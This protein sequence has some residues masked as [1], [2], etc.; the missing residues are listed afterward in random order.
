MLINMDIPWNPAVLEQRIARIYR[1]GQK[2]NVSIINMV[3]AG[4]IEQ[5]MLGVLGFKKGVSEG[6]LDGGDDT[7]FM[8]EGKFKM[9]MQSVETIMDKPVET[10]MVQDRSDVEA[11]LPEISPINEDNTVKAAAESLEILPGD[12]DIAR[13]EPVQKPVEDVNGPA[14]PAALVQMGVSF[15]SQLSQTLANPEATKK[16]VSSIVQKDETDGKT[17][18]KI[19]VENQQMVENAI[20]LF[21]GLM[22]AFN[23]KK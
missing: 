12:D 5:R 19:P 22:G 15:F 10:T 8:E 16:L 18:L 9:F 23:Q 6:I 13:Q 11:E 2:R 14:E 20:T 4:T 3:A 17:Y 1:L 21:A 7:V